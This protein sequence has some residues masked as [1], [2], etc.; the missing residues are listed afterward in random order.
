MRAPCEISLWY[1]LPLIRKGLA[2]E[3]V[4]NHGMT[5]AAVARKL[6]ITDAAVSQYISGKRASGGPDP[7]LFSDEMA[8]AAVTIASAKN[9]VAV[10]NEICRL[11]RHVSANK[12]FKDMMA[13]N[14]CVKC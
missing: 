12:K 9:G 5:Q 6:S 10:Q 3:L 2:R 4:K 7:S 14:K 11:C 8:K 1:V 13:E